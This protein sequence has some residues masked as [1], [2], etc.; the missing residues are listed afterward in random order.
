MKYIEER[1][2]LRDLRTLDKMK[3]H[4]VDCGC[5]EQYKDC[6]EKQFQLLIKYKNNESK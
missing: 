2:V 3:K 1:R 6:K 4:F 5:P